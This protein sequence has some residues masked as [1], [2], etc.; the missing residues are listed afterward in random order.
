MESFV[1]MKVVCIIVLFVVVAEAESMD[2]ETVVKQSNGKTRTN[3]I[4]FKYPPYIDNHQAFAL[5]LLEIC[6]KN[7]RENQ[8]E[9]VQGTTRKP[10]I[11][12]LNVDFKECTFL[13]KR[14]VDTVTLDLPKKTPCGPKNQTCEK[15]EECVGH[16][17]GC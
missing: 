15:K 6:E 5:S 2:E 1:A 4:K 13:C 3:Q 14:D 7:N 12:D 10:R 9:N 8:G 17:P 16:I 11:N